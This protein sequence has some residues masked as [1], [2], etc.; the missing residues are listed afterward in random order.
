MKSFFAEAQ[1]I[2][3]EDY[4]PS[5][6]DLGHAAEKGVIETRCNVERLSLRI[7][8]VCYN[9]QKAWYTKW[10]HLFEGVTSVLFCVSLPDYDEPASRISHPHQRVRTIPLFLCFPRPAVIDDSRDDGRGRQ[11]DAIA[12]M[13]HSFRSSRQLAQVQT[14][15]DHI[16]FHRNGR[17]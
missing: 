10:M 14:N 16:I 6:E 8:H 17:F 5:I 12:R 15:L 2:T 7:L 1:R 9:G 13:S 3:A 11:L 4:V